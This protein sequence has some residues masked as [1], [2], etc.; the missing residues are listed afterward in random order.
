[1]S[2]EHLQKEP[3]TTRHY[4]VRVSGEHPHRHHLNNVNMVRSNLLC[5]LGTRRRA[6][7]RQ[8]QDSSGVDV[9]KKSSCGSGTSAA[10]PEMRRPAPRPR[11]WMG[12]MNRV[13]RRSPPC[14]QTAVAPDSGVAKPRRQT[15]TRVGKEARDGAVNH[16]F[17]RAEAAAV[18]I[19]A[20][21]RG[22]LARRAFRALRSLVRLQ[23]IARG[24]FV[25][26]QAGVA[27]RFMML[28]V[29]LHVRIRARQLVKMSQDH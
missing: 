28:L 23:A 26:K 2:L 17:S 12:R 18:T 10:Q 27:I 13:F 6:N 21:F 19:Q 1:M 25:R 16:E 15:A 20:G 8:H 9:A 3:K 24:S 11:R 7:A 14:G 5:C 22:H 4:S 29:R